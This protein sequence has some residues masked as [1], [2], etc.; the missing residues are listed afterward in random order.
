MSTSIKSL[1]AQS[2][3]TAFVQLGAYSAPSV[4]TGVVMFDLT[5]TNILS[6]PTITVTVQI[7][8]GATTTNW[9]VTAVIL[10]GGAINLCE[11]KPK[12]LASGDQIWIS[13]NVANSCDVTGS[14]SEI[15]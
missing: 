12:A 10:Q 1:K 5:V 8:N 2:I 9:I 11:L 7:R 15:T 14:V 3:G 13:S 4:T 6:G